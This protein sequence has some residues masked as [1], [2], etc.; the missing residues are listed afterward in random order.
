MSVAC[1]SDHTE[2]KFRCLTLFER[3]S[4]YGHISWSTT[5]EPS[6]GPGGQRLESS[7]SVCA[8]QRLCAT[9]HDAHDTL[10]FPTCRPDPI[11]GTT[12]PPPYQETAYRLRLNVLWL[13]TLLVISMFEVVMVVSLLLSTR[14]VGTVLCDL[15][16]NVRRTFSTILDT[17]SSAFDWWVCLPTPS[18]KPAVSLGMSRSAITVVTSSIHCQILEALTSSF[19]GVSMYLHTRTFRLGKTS[20]D[21]STRI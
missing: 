11:R 13:K 15:L 7:L 9:P 16:G 3:P 17:H 14:Q 12:K 19:P 18:N 20:L 8:L 4:F 21:L 10:R 2:N 5:L 1:L 6:V